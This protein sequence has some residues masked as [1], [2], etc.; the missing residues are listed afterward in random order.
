MEQIAENER[1]ERK[2][3]NIRALVEG[4]FKSDPVREL[5]TLNMFMSVLENLKVRG[6][7]DI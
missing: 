7:D 6:K 2:L 5:E 1:S 3:N 4:T